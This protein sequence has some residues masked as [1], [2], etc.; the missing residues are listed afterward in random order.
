MIFEVIAARLAQKFSDLID[1]LSLEP[2]HIVSHDRSILEE[3]ILPYF[4]KN[5]AYQRI[6][7][8]GCSAY[9][10]WYEGFFSGKE[11]WTIDAKRVK[12]KY[13]ADRHVIDSITNVG[14]HFAKNYFDIIIMNGVIGFGLNHIGEIERAVDACYEVLTDRGILLIGWN[15]TTRRMP[16][17]IRAIGSLRKFH[18]HRF[19]P[20]QA[21]HYRTEGSH[22]HTFSFYQ[23]E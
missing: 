5:A 22:R 6:L 16:L 12:R 20:L 2:K 7:F 14:R 1:T 21:C 15:D 10:Q 8:V 9:T 23:K 4:A 18:E 19:V 11:Y 17:D 13:G 3:K